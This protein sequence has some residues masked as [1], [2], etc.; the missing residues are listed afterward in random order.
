MVDENWS[1]SYERGRA[2][3]RIGAES[4]LYSFLCGTTD[5]APVILIVRVRVESEKIR[6]GQE[7][8]EQNVRSLGAIP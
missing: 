6:A 5:G 8:P 7:R 1:R 2:A 3:P 4:V